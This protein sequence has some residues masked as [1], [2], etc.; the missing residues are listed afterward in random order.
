MLILR[1]APALSAFRHSKL[2]EQL[3]QKVPAVTG[4]YAEFAH[5]ADVTGVLTADEQQVLARLLKY[6]P[7]VPVQ[8]PTGRLFLVLPRFGTISP[9]SSK[10]SD[11]AR[12]CGLEKIQRLERGIAFYVAGQFSEAE[13]ELIAGSLHDRMT[14][15]IVSQLEQAGALF[16]HAEPKPL[17]AIDVLGGGRAALAK[18]NTELG[19]ALA[20]DE[21]DYLVSAFNGLKRNPH[22]IELMMFAQANSEHCRHKI[23]N[24]SWDID[25]ESQEKSLFG[26]IK[27][28]YVMHS[29]GVLSAYKDNASVIVGS[30]AGRFFPDPE[31]R[32]YGAVQEPVH[33]LMKVETHN[34]PTA[35]APFPGAATGSGGEI[36]DEGATGRGAKPKAGLTG[37]TVSNLQIPGF[38]QPWEVPYG[39]PERIVTALDIMIEGPLGGAAFNNEFGRPALTG[40]FRTFEQS[41]TTPRGDE[42]RGYHKPIML[43]GG[44]GNIREEHVKKGEILV[45]SKLIVLGGPAMLIGLGGG[46]ASSMATGTSSADL[47]FASVQRENPEMERRCQEVID[48]CWQLG[49]K[50][51]ISFIHDVGAGGLSNAFPELVNDG[52]RGGRFELRNIP[53]DE[54]GMAPHEIWSNESQERYVLAVGP[55]DFARFQA[56]CE[57]ERCPFAVVG[58]ATA[59]PQLTVTDSHF[60]NS[61]VDM[62]LEVLLGKAP[63]MHRSAVRETELGDDFDPSTLELADSIERVLHHPAVASKSFLITIG[64]RT[65][66]GLVAR[67]QMVG[68]WQVPVA[69]VAVTA[70]SFDVYTGE[71][72]AMGERTPL[73]LLDAP[74]SGRMAIGET[75]T[76]IAAS[77]IGKLSD[78]KLS[79][80]WMSA[81]GHPGEDARL[82]DTVKAV[83]M[84]LCPELGITIP[85]GKDSMS[86]ATRWN[87]EGVDKSVTSPLSLIVTGFA[88]VTDIR[89]TLTPQLR[90]DKGTTD[91]IL[92]DLGRGQNRM[93]ASILAQT[94]GKLGK[95][96]PDVD[97]AEDLK[98]FFAVIQGLNADGHL[99]AYHDRSDG[100]LLTSV[101]EMA[102]A[103]HCG[104]N[105][106][107]DSVAEDASEL[108][109][110]LFNEEL[111]AVI[112]VRQDATPN[113]LAQFSAAGLGDC[114]AVIGQPINNGQIDIVFNGDTVFEGQRR[115]LQRQWAETS[116]Q[117]QRLRDNADC[118][119]QEFDV[120]LEEDNP[121]LS[122]KLSFDVNQDIAAPYIKK[123]IRPQ[124]AVL[125]EQG[126][127]GQV[128]MAAAFDRAGF[129]AI[130]VH[131]SDILAGR[132]DLNEFKGLV[133]CGGFSYGDV[134]GAGEGWAKSAL[135]NSRARDAFQGFFERNDSFT[136]GVCNGCQMMSNLHELIPGSEFWP[137]FVRNRSEQFEA[138]VAMVQ[139]QESNSIFLQGMAGS[140]MPIAIAHG[141]GH[142]E[143]A[144]E[145]A[146]LEADVS[147]C[148]AMRFVDNHGK[149][150]E[151]YPA[152]P[153]G[154]PRGITG[155]TSRDGR[156]TIMMP[157]PERVFRA[158]QNSWRPEE[159]NEDGAW[160]RMFRNARV[161]VN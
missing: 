90:M 46:A 156:V 11:I 10:A 16:S 92:I 47:D 103:G 160:M 51:P 94:H 30:V 45:G 84:E 110:I 130:D 95:H 85:V 81:A 5:F 53:N 97:D 93:G 99:L 136:L 150:T 134:L 107:L 75:L 122:T 39:K 158:V 161:W 61:P 19:L 111:G 7:S 15:I 56:I 70:T 117:I 34:H 21:I 98:A 23:F 87:D 116:Y 67:D 17:T 141:E 91:L 72:M 114:V 18:A 115:L 2:L 76:N 79:A 8:E 154:S 20:E 155:L 137:H 68:P 32:Q 128:E 80:N 74:A 159:W 71:A 63:R 41:I 124:V 22:D 64:D 125:R 28:T 35:I 50:N 101:V 1:G 24:A 139:V 44:M 31:T 112:Q 157:H 149:V 119:E 123:G 138:R 6:G 60:G 65:I 126:V 105:L 143:F 133:A 36:R 40:Y 108:N 142:A 153:N 86:M 106:V 148:V 27:N 132:V 73:A 151:S 89:Q 3:S 62:P 14:Q 57:R 42:V 49:D 96:A 118:A 127:N 69:D 146:L 145:E 109:G 29:E 147:G 54:P 129:N 102:F 43:A 104:L 77:R 78:I 38:E 131:M 25:G 37:F 66:T 113:V 135:F 13:A 12:N 33:I 121:G 120:I 58:E 48:R 88:P 140:R 152:N 4:L 9:W 100:G 59:E 26:M 52:E 82:Y 144:S 83:G 55:E